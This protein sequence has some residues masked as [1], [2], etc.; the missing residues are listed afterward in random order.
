MKH[1]QL[2]VSILHSTEFRSAIRIKV[3]GGH[4]AA[5]LKRT[6]SGHALYTRPAMSSLGR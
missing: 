1:V 2:A 5:Y 3:V 4:A 6:V